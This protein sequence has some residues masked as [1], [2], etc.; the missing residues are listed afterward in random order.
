MSYIEHLATF[1]VVTNGFFI[2]FSLFRDSKFMD[3]KAQIDEFRRA[4]FEEMSR[5]VK[6]EA[7]LSSGRPFVLDGNQYRVEKLPQ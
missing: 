3:T 5:R 1:Y 6:I 4:R 2:G 7:L